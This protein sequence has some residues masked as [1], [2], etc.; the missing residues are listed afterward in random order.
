MLTVRDTTD[1]V[2]TVGQPVELFAGI[3]GGG[4]TTARYSVTADGKRF[5]MSAALLTSGE[6][7]AGEDRRPKVVVVQNWIEEL[8]ERVPN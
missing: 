2:L 5:L 7:D 8:K 6:V 4:S 3:G 1:P